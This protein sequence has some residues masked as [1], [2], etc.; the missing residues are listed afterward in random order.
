[1]AALT[2]RYGFSPAEAAAAFS[3]A[4]VPSARAVEAVHLRC[5]HDVDATYELAVGVLGVSS[6]IVT[7]VLVG[8]VPAAVVPPSRPPE[9]DADAL[10]GAGVDGGLET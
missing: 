2:E 4:G 3:A 10:V 9:L 8:D 5:D 6:D 1:L 7:T